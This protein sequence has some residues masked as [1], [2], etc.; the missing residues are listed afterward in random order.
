MASETDK[1]IDQATEFF[2]PRD[3]VERVIIRAA[4]VAAVDITHETGDPESFLG[5]VIDTVGG[6]LTRPAPKMSK[7]ARTF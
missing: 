2:E 3:Q 7:L 5:F 4:V 6:V 1:L